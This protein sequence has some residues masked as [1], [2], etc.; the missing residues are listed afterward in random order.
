MINV[1]QSLYCKSPTCSS[2]LFLFDLCR[3][4]LPQLLNSMREVDFVSQ[5]GRRIHFNA[6]G[7]IPTGYD[8]YNL[9]QTAGTEI[10]KRFSFSKV[11]EHYYL[12]IVAQTWDKF[13]GLQSMD[14]AQAVTQHE[15]G[16]CWRI[17]CGDFYAYI[18]HWTLLIVDIFIV[19]LVGYNACKVVF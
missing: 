14:Q 9:V 18:L 5:Y 19:N 11:Y 1:E 13:N 4:R 2:A 7:N 6:Y 15:T 8:L 17:V 16:F 12:Q 10:A 3:E